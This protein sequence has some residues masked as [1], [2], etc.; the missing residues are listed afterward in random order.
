MNEILPTPEDI[1]KTMDPILLEDEQE[2]TDWLAYSWDIERK[3]VDGGSFITVKPSDQDAPD[4][5]ITI[6]SKSNESKPDITLKVNGKPVTGPPSKLDLLLRQ[7]D[8]AVRNAFNFPRNDKPLVDFFMP[9]VKQVLGIVQQKTDLGEPAFEWHLKSVKEG[10]VPVSAYEAVL[11]GP[12]TSG[13]IRLEAGRMW[14]SPMKY[15]D[16]LRIRKADGG[17]P[18]YE[19]DMSEVEKI[20]IKKQ[21]GVPYDRR[22]ISQILRLQGLY[23][24][25]PA[26]M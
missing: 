11:E 8:K 7:S 25:L 19:R 22:E 9:L 24:R 4:I 3:P 18:K 1:A 14:T 10:D 2:K 12:G 26:F 17:R 15:V 20:H 21:L 16:F 5:I 13:Q 23:D 6:K